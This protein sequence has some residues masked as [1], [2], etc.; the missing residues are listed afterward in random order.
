MGHSELGLLLFNDMDANL[1]LEDS[2]KEP[3]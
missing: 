2:G 1:T 3:E